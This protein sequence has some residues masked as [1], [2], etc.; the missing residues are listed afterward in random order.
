[1]LPTTRV[2]TIATFVLNRLTAESRRSRS[3]TFTGR[4]ARRAA[5][6]GWRMCW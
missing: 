1:M 2:I 4:S 6:R 3:A 5:M